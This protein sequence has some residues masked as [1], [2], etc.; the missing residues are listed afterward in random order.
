MSSDSNDAVIPCARIMGILNLTPDSFSDGGKFLDP[1][2]AIDHAAKMIADGASII[3][4]GAES[5]RP[6][7]HPIAA[8][9]Q[10]TRLLPILHALRAKA[11]LEVKLSIDTRSAIVA[12]A[13]LSEG[14]DI[15]NDVSA[16][17][18][19]PRMPEVLAKSPHAHVILM[20]MQGTP[21]TMQ[22][23]PTY[24]D[25]VREIIAFFQER[26][27]ACERSGINSNRVWLDPGFGFGK[28]FDHN[29]EIARRF[30]EFTALGRPLVAGV[31]RKAFIGRL[32]GKTIPAERDAASIAAAMVLAQ[33]GASILRVHDVAGHITALKVFESLQQS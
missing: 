14:A 6:G 21:E 27:T 15:V 32:S 25:V 13:C 23:D 11:N 26:V 8:A 20:H 18:H 4:L 29:L 30:H 16:L 22:D 7:S 17:R 19:D 12:E 10:L 24:D 33:R 28:S 5:T 1:S 3:D 2:A 9:D 31:S